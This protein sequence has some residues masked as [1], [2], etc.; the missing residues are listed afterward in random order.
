MMVQPADLSF[1]NKVSAIS[2]QMI[3][4]LVICNSW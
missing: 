2:V 1:E 3:F 4:K